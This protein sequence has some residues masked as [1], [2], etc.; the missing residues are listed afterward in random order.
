MTCR[1][2]GVTRVSVLA[3]LCVCSSIDC[4]FA[5]PVE[6]SFVPEA[7]EMKTQW[8]LMGE[9]IKNNR[10]LVSY[11]KG[12]DV[13]CQNGKPWTSLCSSEISQMKKENHCV[14]SLSKGNQSKRKP[15]NIETKKLKSHHG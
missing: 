11:K 8:P 14:I 15:E 10:T 6:R 12:A 9:Q 2:S 13:V 1:L 7:K 5:E 4:V 3:T